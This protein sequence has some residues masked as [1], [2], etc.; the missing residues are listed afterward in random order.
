[1]KEEKEQR[2]SELPK[3]LITL[4][5]P[6]LIGKG[7]VV[8]FGTRYSSYPGEGYGY[9]LAAAITFTLVSFAR[10]LWKFRDYED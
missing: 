7:F 8:F 3:F 9:G 6:T 2:K 5:M 4:L 10:F 1:M